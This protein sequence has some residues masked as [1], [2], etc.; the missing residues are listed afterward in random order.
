MYIS[1]SGAEK[2]SRLLPYRRDK[3]LK[4]IN[5]ER[6]ISIILRKIKNKYDKKL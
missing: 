4:G 2:I 5:A 1:N 3:T 6:Q